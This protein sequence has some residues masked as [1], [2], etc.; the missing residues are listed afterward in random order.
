MQFQWPHDVLLIA[1]KLQDSQPSDAD[2]IPCK[3][4]TFLS[5]AVFKPA[6]GPIQPRIQHVS[7]SSFL[8][9]GG[10]GQD[11]NL[12]IYP[13]PVSRL[14]IGGAKI[15]LPHTSLSE[16]KLR[17]GTNVPSGYIF[18]VYNVANLMFAI[19]KCLTHI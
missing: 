4:K 16:T 7:D 12:T 14:R 11:L 5:S 9:G 8:G 1:T 17:T 18:L 3:D 19:P 10:K 15:P 13:N 2:G 6:L